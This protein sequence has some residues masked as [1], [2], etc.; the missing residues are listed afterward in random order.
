MAALLRFGMDGLDTDRIVRWDGDTA[1]NTLSVWLDGATGPMVYPSPM[2]NEQ[3]LDIVAK[4]RSG[5]KYTQ[6]LGNENSS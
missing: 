3:D 4:P 2:R 1:N 5:D 6:L